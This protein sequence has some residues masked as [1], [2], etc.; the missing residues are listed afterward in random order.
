[1]G[2]TRVDIIDKLR[3]EANR[4]PHEPVWREAI[5]EIMILRQ[6]FEA[7]KQAALR[8]HRLTALLQ[9][10]Y[11]EGTFESDKLDVCCH[12]K[13]FLD[14]RDVCAELYWTNKRDGILDLGSAIDAT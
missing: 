2:A 7:N 4:E 13:G 5:D 8:F 1:M 9:H 12:A 11:D 14:K 10:A 6:K 3:I